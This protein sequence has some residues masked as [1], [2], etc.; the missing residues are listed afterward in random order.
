MGVWELVS[1]RAPMQDQAEAEA[2]WEITPLLTCSF[3]IQLSQLATWPLLG[4][5]P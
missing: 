5:T 1:G 2:P 3:S 4:R